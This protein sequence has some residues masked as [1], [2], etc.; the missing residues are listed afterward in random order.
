MTHY[1]QLLR[2]LVAPKAH[3]TG[4]YK[5]PTLKSSV[6]AYLEQAELYFQPND[7]VDDKQ[8]AESLSNIEAKTYRLLRS[9]VAPKAP[10]EKC[11]ARGA[12]GL[13]WACLNK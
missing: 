10:K 9:L 12:C 8:V 2:S 7:V 5:S 1:G 3:A 13:K 6:T 11:A 4:Y